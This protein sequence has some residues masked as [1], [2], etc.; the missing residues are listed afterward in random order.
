MFQIVYISLIYQTNKNTNKM[1]NVTK[2]MDL[3][4]AFLLANKQEI[5][6]SNVIG[7]M[8]NFSN[9]EH[10]YYALLW[11]KYNDLK[12]TAKALSTT[13]KTPS[14]SLCAMLAARNIDTTINF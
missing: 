5:N 8:L 1:T 12:P 4:K 14:F 11:L 9:I 7:V 3:A 2:K 10:T 6:S 13:L